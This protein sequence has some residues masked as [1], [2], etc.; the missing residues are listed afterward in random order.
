MTIHAEHIVPYIG[1]Q[2]SG[3]AWSVPALCSALLAHGVVVRMHT[4]AP[5]PDRHFDF[6]VA[7]YPRHALPDR[8]IGR[9]PKMK[10]GLHQAAAN[11]QILHNHSLWMMP[12]I[13]PAH[14]VRGTQCR[15]VVS[16][17]GTFSDWA[18]RR[19]QWLKRLILALGQRRVLEEAACFH[20]TATSEYEEIRRMRLRA[21]VAILPNGVDIPS[22]HFKPQPRNQTRR[23]LL[24]LSR[25]HP[26]KRVALLLSAW[27]NL[28]LSFPDWELRIVGP[29]NG[30]YAM[31]MQRLAE[32]L[33]CRRVWFPGAAYGPAKAREY[34]DA[35]LFV[36]PTHSEN[37]GMVVAEALAHGLPAVVTKGAPW[38][39]L[40]A[41]QCG[42]WIDMG[43]AALTECLRDALT[44][45]PAELET[46]GQRGRDWM[47]REFCWREIGRKMLLTYEWLLDGGAQPDWVITE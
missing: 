35:D 3:P 42:W 5:L 38:A 19:S 10:R 25:I 7:E 18:L 16:P 12:N 14:A 37:F 15:L 6:E 41:E 4:L 2:S 8:R 26:K 46:M 30:R 21:P 1:N 44:R 27:R 23:R 34:F 40:E 32:E 28:Q 43:E 11:A 47:R 45:T 29:D 13:Y 39:G 9:S 20:A 22:P 36:L 31:Q 33:G 17:R 24:F